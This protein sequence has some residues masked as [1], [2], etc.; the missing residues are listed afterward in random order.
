MAWKHTST[1]MY[2]HETWYHKPRHITRLLYEQRGVC[3]CV[4]GGW[5]SWGS[6]KRCNIPPPPPPSSTPL[7][8]RYHLFVVFNW[9]QR[10]QEARVLYKPYPVWVCAGE[11]IPPQTLIVILSWCRG[12]CRA[13]TAK[14]TAG[15]SGRWGRMWGGGGGYVYMCALS[16]DWANC[17]HRIIDGTQLSK[18]VLL[19]CLL[20]YQ[21]TIIFFLFYFFKFFVG[22]LLINPSRSVTL[23]TLCDHNHL[24]DSTRQVFLSNWIFHSVE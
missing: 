19:N 10:A 5:S 21:L 22:F 16:G 12:I 24:K 23:Q 14:P 7:A 2:T 8:S 6:M 1:C 15:L 4:K 17:T 11:L 13:P 18:P 20:F 9:Q 3:L